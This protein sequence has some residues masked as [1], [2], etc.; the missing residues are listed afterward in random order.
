MAILV[1]RSVTIVSIHLLTS[2]GDVKCAASQAW[3]LLD[4]SGSIDEGLVKFSISENP[5]QLKHEDIWIILPKCST[6]PNH[7]DFQQE[8]RVSEG[9]AHVRGEAS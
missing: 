8:S 9:C 6:E 5:K 3:N 4:A 2:D 7:S 1:Y